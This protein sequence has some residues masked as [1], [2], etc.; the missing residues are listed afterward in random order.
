MTIVYSD[1]KSKGDNNESVL[2]SYLEA[3]INSQSEQQ[4]LTSKFNY[5]FIITSI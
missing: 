4:P 5:I 2:A 3:S 1:D